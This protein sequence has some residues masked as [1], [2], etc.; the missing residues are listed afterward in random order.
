MTTYLVIRNGQVKMPLLNPTI[1]ADGT[2]W[3]KGMPVLD[4]QSD[5]GKKIGIDRLTALTRA[6]D[7]AN[8]PA[9]CFAKVGVNP[10][11]L[12]VITQ[13]EYRAQSR[14]EVEAARAARTPAQVERDR[15]SG[16]YR[17]AY[18]RRDASDD[19]NVMDYYRI[20]G[21]ADAALAKWREDYPEEAKEERRAELRAKAE[22]ERELA[23]GALFYDS[24]GWLDEAARQARHD[25]F[26]ARAE[27]LEAEATNL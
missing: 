3:I 6:K 4:S 17:K 24:D 16:L 11:G 23:Q 21:Q 1:K 19:C 13:A 22:K 26:I 2:V 20:K 9:D 15:I 18:Q 12:T 27:A 14:A 25:E 10:S 8:I 7:Y 5:G